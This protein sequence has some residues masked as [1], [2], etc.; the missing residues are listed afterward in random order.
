MKRNVSL[1]WRGATRN[2][3]TG[4]D[5]NLWRLDASNE[6]FIIAWNISISRRNAEGLEPPSRSVEPQS[7]RSQSEEQLHLSDTL[8]SDC[9]LCERYGAG[10]GG[11]EGGCRGV[12]NYVCDREI[13]RRHRCGWVCVCVCVRHVEHELN[14]S[15]NGGET[16]QLQLQARANALKRGAI[17]PLIILLANTSAKCWHFCVAL[18]RNS[19]THN[20][21][22]KFI[23]TSR[24]SS[25]CREAA[26]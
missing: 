12:I 10:R 9:I 19:C 8:K 25:L 21:L 2:L 1:H 26:L 5:L 23:Q 15:A 13:L 20:A 4:C 3:K 24:F 16:W 11:T 22:R 18:F 14:V 6:V 7:A 17:V